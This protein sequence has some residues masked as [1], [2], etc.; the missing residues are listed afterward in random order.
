MLR[1]TPFLLTAGFLGLVACA[2]GSALEDGA[3]GGAGGT[4]G[5]GGEN[6]TT[7]SATT[8][9]QTTTGGQGG[10][11]GAGGGAGNT[12]A[13]TGTGQACDFMALN[14]CPSAEIMMPIAGDE[15]SP[16]VTKGGSA[17]RWFKIKVE[18]RDSSIFS[19]P[20]LSYRVTLTSPPGMDYALTVYEGSDGV[21]PANCS[22]SA[23]AGSG[24]P[25]TVNR[26][27]EDT[28]G[29][30]G[31]DNSRWVIIEVEWVGGTACGPSDSWTLLVQGDT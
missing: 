1:R 2:E 23:I 14:D 21:N 11:P 29:I 18:E 12:T 27:W 3:G 26:S 30:G 16:S 6:R 10:D 22:A 25:E 13:T 17:S 19:A 24:T 9:A 20:P 31:V 28:Q 8:A 7:T 5:S 4:D 15:S